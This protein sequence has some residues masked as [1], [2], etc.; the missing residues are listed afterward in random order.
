MPDLPKIENAA[1][2]K[3]FAEQLL[4]IFQQDSRVESYIGEKGVRFPNQEKD[5]DLRKKQGQEWKNEQNGPASKLEVFTNQMEVFYKTIEEITTC[6]EEDLNAKW[7]NLEVDLEDLNRITQRDGAPADL[8]DEY[9]Q[10]YGPKNLADSYMVYAQGMRD[11]I[12]YVSTELD[13]KNRSLA[14]EAKNQKEREELER[15]ISQITENE[16]QIAQE[17]NTMQVNL[18]ELQAKLQTGRNVLET[19]EVELQTAERNYRKGDRKNL[20]TAKKEYNA[21]KLEYETNHNNL[22]E[23]SGKTVSRE[24]E[25]KLSE[26][27][28]GIQEKRE[29]IQK[30]ETDIGQKYQE[31]SFYD[32]SIEEHENRIK[33]LGDEQQAARGRHKQAVEKYLK[34]SQQYADILR[35]MDTLTQLKDTMPDIKRFNEASDKYVPILY[36][37]R[38]GL[39]YEHPKIKELF[40]ESELDQDRAYSNAVD[41]LA[42]GLGDLDPNTGTMEVV[43][44][45][46]KMEDKGNQELFDDLLNKDSYVG[47]II[48]KIEQDRKEL[49]NDKELRTYLAKTEQI[50]KEQVQLDVLKQK[51]EQKL[52]D[53]DKLTQL[54]QEL[55][56]DTDSYRSMAFDMS[57][58]L[59][60]GY[61]HGE[62][63]FKPENYEEFSKMESGR[64]VKNQK[65]LDELNSKNKELDTQM[66]EKKTKLNQ[67][68]SRVSAL[69]IARDKQKSAE[70]Q[71]S[72]LSNLVSMV[73]K[74]GELIQNKNQI[75]DQR[76]IERKNTTIPIRNVEYLSALQ[77]ITKLLPEDKA[78]NNSDEYKK[79]QEQ[80]EKARKLFNG[81]EKGDRKKVI[82]DLQKSA[83]AYLDEKNSQWRPFPSEQ[84]VTRMTGAKDLLEFCK[85]A[86]RQ[87][88]KDEAA[89]KLSDERNADYEKR[90]PVQEFIRDMDKRKGSIYHPEPSKA[91]K[92]P[93]KDINPVIEVPKK[94]RVKGDP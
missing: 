13:D 30:L 56:Q 51:K 32:S 2:R 83:K 93:E 17:C 54:K 26:L 18:G 21:V 43:S 49:R 74:T 14:E 75:L 81:E 1:E 60:M 23:V 66:Q 28:T 87:L 55:E 15:M 10:Q 5:A 22:I 73:E 25:K 12:Q 58:R 94:V 91:Q 57:N 37:Q 84:R 59:K 62:E 70:S 63:I 8:V 50:E 33:K 72:K 68:Q 35:A 34:G 71:V 61:Q 27:N 39:F 53:T 24:D 4:E 80:L 85:N 82:E 69:D 40:T 19:A 36:L 9:S 79:M 41:T 29:S 7:H 86:Q 44:H 6:D 38:G 67:I 78:K 90:T 45:I 16:D 92:K 47:K 52:A 89:A 77:K 65:L 46:A 3:K 88:I 11:I 48:K 31:D 20:E 64:N 76:A 42:K